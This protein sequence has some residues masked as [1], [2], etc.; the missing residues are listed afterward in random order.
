MIITIKFKTKQSDKQ[1]KLKYIN[2]S[3]IL[4]YTKYD[5]EVMKSFK[6]EMI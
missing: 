4:A 5:R 3:M 6:K 1:K 2:Q